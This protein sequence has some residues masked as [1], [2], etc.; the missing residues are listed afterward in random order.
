MGDSRQMTPEEILSL[1]VE[2][3]KF[4]QKMKLVVDRYNAG[5]MDMLDLADWAKSGIRETRGSQMESY[6]SRYSW[7]DLY[8]E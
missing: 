6:A 5:E 2:Y 8:E 3:S 4:Y 7:D 1:M